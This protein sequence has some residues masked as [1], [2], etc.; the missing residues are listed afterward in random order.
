M[1]RK[2]R[3]AKNITAEDSAVRAE[4]SSETAR[5]KLRTRR[6]SRARTTSA[7]RRGFKRSQLSDAQREQARTLI[8][9]QPPLTET[10]IAQRVGC[11]RFAIRHL[12]SGTQDTATKALRYYGKRLSKELPLK[13]RVKAYAEL[14][15][16]NIDAKR[17]F[18]ALKALQRI[19]ELEGIVTKKEQKEAESREAPVAP[20]PVFVIQGAQINIGA[21]I[22][23]QGTKRATVDVVASLP[24]AELEPI[25]SV[26]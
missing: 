1:P 11:T 7:P 10:E 6:D 12:R 25:E 19:E 18:S 15:R 8:A 3:Q 21:D 2:V 16:G 13:E 22:N 4:N 17:A 26:S 14:A 24:S 20:G 23:P 5:K 9:A